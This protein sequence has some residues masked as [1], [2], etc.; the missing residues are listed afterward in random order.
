MEQLDSIY[1]ATTDPVAKENIKE[2][3]LDVNSFG[4]EIFHITHICE[5]ALRG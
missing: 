2:K 1:G 4:D 5:K 3:I